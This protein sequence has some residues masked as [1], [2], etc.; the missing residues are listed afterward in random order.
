LTTFIAMLL[1]VNTFLKG[2]N[3]VT[4][5]HKTLAFSVII[6]A[7]AITVIS[8]GVVLVGVFILELT[9]DSPFLANL[10]EVVSA[11]GTV[12]LSMGITGNLDGIGK[13][14]IIVIM[15]VG[16]LGPLTL[17]FIFASKK[18][19]KIRYPEERS[20]D[21]LKWFLINFFM[22]GHQMVKIIEIAKRPVT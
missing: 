17:A 4:I 9:Q 10:F 11:F 7:L 12:G 19:P 20:T 14:T 21:R 5:F 2:K 22:N 3:E 15:M 16:K 13:L 18:T 8:T 1:S 6:K